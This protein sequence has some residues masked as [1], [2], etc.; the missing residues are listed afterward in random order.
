MGSTRL[1]GKVLKQIDGR[2]MLSYQ[3]E[4][5]RRASLVN[6]IVIA[7]S[8]AKADDAIVRSTLL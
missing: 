7:T 1:R 4:R 2:A 3:L 5:L 6:E 8:T